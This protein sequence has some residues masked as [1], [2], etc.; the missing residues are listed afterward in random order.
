[1][2]L[3]IAGREESDHNDK[4]LAEPGLHAIIVIFCFL[5]GYVVKN[6]INSIALLM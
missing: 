2:S 4:L 5:L 1:M 3:L 6:D